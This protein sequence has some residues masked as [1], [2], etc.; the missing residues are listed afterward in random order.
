MT[1]NEAWEKY[2]EEYDWEIE[3][4]NFLAEEVLGL[5]DE[6]LDDIFYRVCQR[7]LEYCSEKY[8]INL[9]IEESV[10]AIWFLKEH[11]L[12]KRG[13]TSSLFACELTE[14]GKEVLEWMKEQNRK[15]NENEAK[16]SELV[17]EG[18]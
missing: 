3:P 6:N 1:I 5:G 14:K 11:G 2:Q 8:R 7:T 16:S 15:E 13:I 18:N 9:P 17:T 12:L 10:F 4:E